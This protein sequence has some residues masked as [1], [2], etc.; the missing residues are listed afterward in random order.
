MSLQPLL[1]ILQLDLMLNP[2]LPDHNRNRRSSS[3]NIIDPVV[4]TKHAQALR[5]R[6]IERSRRHF[7]RMLDPFQ[8]AARHGAGAKGHAESYN[9]FAIYSLL[10]ISTLYIAAGISREEWNW[11][12]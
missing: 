3:A 10:R 6:F 4:F 5:D 11:A 8:V 1:E 2:R 7:N 12:R 9:V